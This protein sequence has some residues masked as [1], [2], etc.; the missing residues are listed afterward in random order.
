[1]EAAQ[2][3]VAIAQTAVPAL[4]T[5]LPSIADQLRPLLGNA[6]VD[7][8]TTPEDAVND[9]VT[10]LTITGTD[11]TGTLSQLDA[12]ARDG[13]ASAALL[14]ASRYY[15]KATIVLDVRD[16]SG[17]TLVHATHEAQ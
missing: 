10:N 9:A 12:R 4:P 1:M 3:A 6:S 17:A 5:G 11:I 15:P 13:A 14:L 2:T 16:A 8:R 7:I